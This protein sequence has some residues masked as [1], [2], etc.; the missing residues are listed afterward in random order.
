MSTS[1]PKLR[2]SSAGSFPQGEWRKERGGGGEERGE[3]E[4]RG[5]RR[6]E[7]EGRRGKVLRECM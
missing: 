1:P 3:E 2:G 6:K 5:G 4:R 7:S